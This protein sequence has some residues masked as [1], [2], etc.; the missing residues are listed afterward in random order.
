[1]ILPPRI[2]RRQ[3]WQKS[4]STDLAPS[5]YRL[6]SKLK[7]FLGD[8]RFANDEELKAMVSKWFQMGARDF[9]NGMKKL[10]SHSQKCIARNG[11]YVKKWCSF[12]GGAAMTFVTYLVIQ[13]SRKIIVI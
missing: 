13:V 3:P 6:F 10:F 9:T 8:R 12:F 2:R 4:Q 7:Q 1:M 5:D 11:N